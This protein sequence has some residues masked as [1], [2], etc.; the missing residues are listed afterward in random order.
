MIL[1]KEDCVIDQCI[2]SQANNNVN[3]AKN[4]ATAKFQFLY[5]FILMV[6]ASALTVASLINAI[7]P[8]E[9]I[10][11]IAFGAAASGRTAV[12][13]ACSQIKLDTNETYSIWGLKDLIKHEVGSADYIEASYDHIEE[14]LSLTPKKILAFVIRLNCLRVA[15]SEYNRIKLA[16]SFLSPN[17]PYYIVYIGSKRVHLVDFDAE[18]QKQFL[19]YHQPTGYLAVEEFNEE[20]QASIDKFNEKVGVFFRKARPFSSTIH[21]KGMYFGGKLGPMLGQVVRLIKLNLHLQVNLKPPEDPKESQEP[22]KGKTLEDKLLHTTPGGV[23]L[24]SHQPFLGDNLLCTT[25]DDVCLK[26]VHQSFLQDN[27]K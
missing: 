17:T 3:Q 23:C 16:L 27:R 26:D 19:E 22:T 13:S 8:V 1:P 20:D 14:A 5:F 4:L 24:K 18:H 9:K 12:L 2:Q 11:F 21:F 15:G 6:L 7:A 25:P 10:G